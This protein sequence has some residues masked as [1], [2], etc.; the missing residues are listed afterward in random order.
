VIDALKNAH[1]IL[2]VDPTV[3]ELAEGRHWAEIQPEFKAMPC[4]KPC[5]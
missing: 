5:R 2:F 4:P 1:A 3:E